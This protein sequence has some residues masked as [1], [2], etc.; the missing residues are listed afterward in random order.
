[1]HLHRLVQ[2]LI[3]AEPDQQDPVPGYLQLRPLPNPFRVLHR[4]RG[5]PQHD[6][7]PVN[8]LIGQSSTSNQN[9]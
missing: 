5:Q 1:M 6:G 9:G 2:L 3:E 7:Q 4:Q 8:D